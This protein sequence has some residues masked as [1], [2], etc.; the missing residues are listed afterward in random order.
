MNSSQAGT[1]TSPT[2]AFPGSAGGLHMRTTS[3]AANDNIANILAMAETVR[4]VLPHIPDEL[5][6]QD[7]QRTNSVTVTVNN[8]LQILSM[9]ACNARSLG[10]VPK[11]DFRGQLHIERKVAE[12]IGLNMDSVQK[13]AANGENIT[14]RNHGAAISQKPKE[15]KA[16]NKEM[17]Y[18]EK[19][20]SEMAHAGSEIVEISSHV[21]L[22]KATKIEGSSW[23]ARSVLE[24]GSHDKEEE[25]HSTKNG[26]HEDTVDRDYE[27]PHRKPPIHNKKT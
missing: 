15:S 11:G 19:T 12:K 18:S 9:H 22:L 6:F 4:E 3:R 7:L 10:I 1:S 20:T 26:V 5:I 13:G 21:S 16:H 24:F 14:D 25:M 27:Q 17:K 2:P 23:L 8:L